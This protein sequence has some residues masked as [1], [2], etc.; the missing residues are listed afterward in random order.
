MAGRS[1]SLVGMMR[2]NARGLH[3]PEPGLGNETP[4]YTPGG[5]DG[6]A[7]FWIGIEPTGDIGCPGE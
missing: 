1:T 7:Y 5:A 4:N 2:F 6:C 3:Q